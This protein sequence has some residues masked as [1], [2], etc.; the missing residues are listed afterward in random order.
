VSDRPLCLAIS[1][2]MP[3]LPP[4]PTAH[5]AG[6]A[7][8]ETVVKATGLRRLMPSVEHAPLISVDESRGLLETGGD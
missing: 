7:V 6:A 3:W 4:T 1:G 5:G 2:W 8:R